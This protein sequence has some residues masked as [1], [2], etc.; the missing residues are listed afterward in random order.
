MSLTRH[1]GGGLARVDFF[2]SR[3]KYTG[4]SYSFLTEPAFYSPDFFRGYDKSGAKI[5]VDA[6]RRAYSIKTI[7]LTQARKEEF[8]DNPSN[9]VDP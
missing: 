1:Q 4:G 5:L 3:C 7:H 8:F 2:C 9:F 6:I